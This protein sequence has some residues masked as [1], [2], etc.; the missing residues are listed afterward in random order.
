MLLPDADGALCSPPH[1]RARTLGA[2]RFVYQTPTMVQ[3]V[4]NRGG[5]S[6]GGGTW[7]NVLLNKPHHGLPAASVRHAAR[8]ESADVPKPV[9]VA[10]PEAHPPVFMLDTP[11]AYLVDHPD[12][13]ALSPA[14]CVRH[15]AAMHIASAIGV[16]PTFSPETGSEV[17]LP[18]VV[19]VVHFKP[20]PDAGTGF[21]DYASA[22]SALMSGAARAQD[23]LPTHAI[24]P[25]SAPGWLTVVAAL[26][27]ALSGRRDY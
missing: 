1:E 19:S 3:P 8:L 12:Q 4:G 13:K 18:P 25:H 9:L 16:S 26:L 21:K 15:I 2:L 22:Q 7:K 10:L 24:L 20:V 23:P 27:R 5:F 14:E 6:E 11:R 17:S